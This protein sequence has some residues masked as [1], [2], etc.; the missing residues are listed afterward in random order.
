MFSSGIWWSGL[1]VNLWGS[2]RRFDD[3]LGRIE[4]EFPAGTLCL[5]AEKPG[6]IIAF[7]FRDPPG[8]LR[9]AGLGERALELEARY[10]LEFRRFVDALRR[11][12]RSDAERLYPGGKR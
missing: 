11:M 1:A 7:G 6:N 10:G 4:A 2:D 8:E 9:W 3:Y 12:N 5:P